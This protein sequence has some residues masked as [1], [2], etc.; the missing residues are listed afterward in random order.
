MLHYETA[1][2]DVDLF[3]QPISQFFAKALRIVSRETTFARGVELFPPDYIAA[4]R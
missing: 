3:Q 4:T 2:P 1:Q